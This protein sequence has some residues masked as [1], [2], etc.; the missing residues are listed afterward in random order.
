MFG[1]PHTGLSIELHCAGMIRHG[2]ISDRLDLLR[3]FFELWMDRLQ[4]SVI[5]PPRLKQSGDSAIAYFR[6]GGKMQRIS[7][8]VRV[9]SDT[10]GA[11]LLDDGPAVLGENIVGSLA[12][13]QTQKP[14]WLHGVGFLIDTDADGGKCRVNFSLWN[15][16]D[17]LV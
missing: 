11:I 17:R 16:A 5:V 7:D 8:Y 14:N 10:R 6:R 1:S 12:G 2:E 13:R 9:T 4:F 15:T 3:P